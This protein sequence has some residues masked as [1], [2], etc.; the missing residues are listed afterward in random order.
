[1]VRSRT[2]A[3]TSLLSILLSMTLVSLPWGSAVHAAVSVNLAWTAPGDDSLSGVATRYDLRMSTQPI[4]DANF[5]ASTTVTGVPA[6]AAPF[7]RQTVKVSNLTESTVYYF[8]LKTADERGNWSRM[9]NVVIFTG[10]VPVQPPPT[11]ALSFSAPQPNPASDRTRLVFDLPRAAET[12]IDV[13]DVVGRRVRVLTSGFLPQGRT[14]VNWQLDDDQ[15]RPLP[16]GL[17]LV[18]ARALGEV[19]LRR[20]TV[21]R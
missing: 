11:L 5:A 12:W 13:L 19:F 6:P 17:Y 7:T 10:T 4:N 9:S 16:A 8:A 2:I 18:R 20:I 14:E 3:Y 1:M 21:I 15:S